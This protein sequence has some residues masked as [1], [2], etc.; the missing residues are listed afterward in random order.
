MDFIKEEIVRVDS[1]YRKNK[2]DAIK[3]T[4]PNKLGNAYDPEFF[5]GRKKMYNGPRGFD[6]AMATGEDIINNELDLDMLNL[7]KDKDD[8]LNELNSEKKDEDEK[9]SNLNK[10]KASKKRF[11]NFFNQGDNGILKPQKLDRKTRTRIQMIKEKLKTK[12]IN[13]LEEEFEDKNEQREKEIQDFAD[14]DLS[15]EEFFKINFFSRNIIVNALFNISIFH[16][17]WKK[18]TLLLTEIAL[19]TLFISIFLTSYEKVTSSNI[20]LIILFSLIS[21]L[22]TNLTLY[23]LAFF[24]FFPP[25]K[26]RRLLYLVKEN[27]NLIILKEWNEM[28]LTQGYKAF[29]GYALCFII[30]GISYYVTFGFTVVWK[31]Q[32]SA[33]Y[34]CLII[35]FI[36]EFL[37]FELV[38]ELLIALFFEKRRIYNW[39]RTIGEFLNR[40]RNYRCLSP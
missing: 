17:R 33:F 29:F 24:F 35:C 38:V 39:M 2:E 25:I 7:F 21:S 3:K 20:G 8:K 9:D 11:N 10:T 32:N 34:L 31:Y 30:W 6:G 13:D 16:P 4:I 15:T 5:G 1:H 12:K 19:I 27:G 23:L 26:F 40:I 28:S 18:L 36:L 22:A 37:L 14:L